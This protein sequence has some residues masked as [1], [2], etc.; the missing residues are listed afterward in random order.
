[1][2]ILHN[3]VAYFAGDIDRTCWR[4]GNSDLSQLF[5]N[6][7]NWVR[8]TDPIVSIEGAGLIEAFAWETEAG[9]ALHVL[10]YTN[11]N[12]TH[13]A[14]RNSYPLGPQRV[15]F[16]IKEGHTVKSVRALRA[17]ATLEFQQQLETVTFELPGIVDYEVVA[18]V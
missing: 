16:R 2:P 3:G 11:P 1:M 5:Q 14:I 10:N 6:A 15:R 18:L 13:G 4:S 8:G 17:A 12:M 9:Y 7:M